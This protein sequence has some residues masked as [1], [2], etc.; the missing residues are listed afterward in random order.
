[1]E[2]PSKI[3]YKRKEATNKK[4]QLTL[5]FLI[6]YFENVTNLNDNVLVDEVNFFRQNLTASITTLADSI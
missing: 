5:T 2:F 4:K 3:G 1:M 6:L